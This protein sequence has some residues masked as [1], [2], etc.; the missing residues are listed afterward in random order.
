[1]GGWLLTFVLVPQPASGQQA[2]ANLLGLREISSWVG[3]G[4]KQGQGPP[5]QW[6]MNGGEERRQPQGGMSPLRSFRAAAPQ[7]PKILVLLISRPSI[8][9]LI[10]AHC[11]RLSFGATWCLAR[12][13]PLSVILFSR[14]VASAAAS[15]G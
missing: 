6:R 7:G 15:K 12:R 14:P 11:P 5:A 9:E 4:D 8:A 3:A 13:F 1:M 10:P 2:Q